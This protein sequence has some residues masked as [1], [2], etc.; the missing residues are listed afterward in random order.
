MPVGYADGFR[1]DLTGAEVRVAGEPRRVVGTVSMDAFAVELDRDLPVATPVVIIGRG[2]LAEAHA[3][4]AD[5]I[6]YELVCGIATGPRPR[7]SRRRRWLTTDSRARRARFAALQDARAA[8][9]DERVRAFVLLGWATSIASTSAAA[10]ARSRSRSRRTS[11]DVVGVDRVPELLELAR[12]R[13]PANATFVEGDA[14]RPHVR[15]R[16]VRSRGDAADAPP[17][18]AARARARGA[19]PA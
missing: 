6:T 17:R 5:T 3:R 16:V 19:R 18:A 9:L 11:R 8:E 12:E 13:A 15:R 1:R 4:V 14:E 7:T 2:V 10:P